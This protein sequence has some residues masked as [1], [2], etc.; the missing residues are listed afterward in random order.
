MTAQEFALG[1]RRNRYKKF[2]QSF[3]RAANEK[4]DIIAKCQRCG[5]EAVDTFCPCKIKCPKCKKIVWA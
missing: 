1:K 5:G 3:L 2:Q 4:Y